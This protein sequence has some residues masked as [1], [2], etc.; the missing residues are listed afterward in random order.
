MKEVKMK[1]AQL[2]PTL[3]NPKDYTVHGILQ[4]R[5]L[6]WVAF[7]F[8]GDF[9]NPGIKPVSCFAGRF[10]ISLATRHNYT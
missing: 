2:C 3:C 9:P 7:P 6:K 8:S 1:I 4:A 10:F 5:M